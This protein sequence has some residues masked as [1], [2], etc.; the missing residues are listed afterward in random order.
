[1]GLKE[2]QL[3]GY[4][5]SGVGVKGSVF[6]LPYTTDTAD[7][8]IIPVPWDVT[9]SYHD[10]TANAPDAVL[11]AS[12][13]LDHELYNFKDAWMVGQTML[14]INSTIK[15]KSARLRE[16]SK[17]HIHALEAGE[18]VDERL[19][20]DVNKGSRELNDW[21]FK[22]AN[23]WLDQG[24]IVACL[25]G[26]HSTP[27]GLIN[28]YAEKFK[29]F[30]ILQIDAHMDLRVA[31]EGFEYSHASIM[32]NALKNESIKKL[33]QIGIRDYCKEELDHPAFKSGRMKVFFDQEIKEC[34]FH[35]D[36]WR[37]I[38]M[39]IVAQLP[40]TLYISFDIDGLN[41]SLCPNTGTPVPGGLY[42]PRIQYLLA[43][44]VRANKKIIGFDLS[45]VGVSE[46]TEWDANVGARVLYN[47]SIHTAASQGL[48]KIN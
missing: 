4:N 23:N 29:S 1:M 35:G 2:E 43:E 44:I 42:L 48:I 11:E 46:N 17:K 19:L 3:K 13:Q 32:H 12:V 25:G 36:S 24:K 18:E 30:G 34:M 22:E 41:P 5:S 7:I 33:V 6:G 45:E 31:Y 26:D 38:T 16:L 37:D 28:A 47:L 21:L 40:D 27:L 39:D 15:N 9:V 20:N 14:P 8:V 10:G